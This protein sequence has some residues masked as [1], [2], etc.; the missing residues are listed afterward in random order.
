MLVKDGFKKKK[1]SIVGNK[2]EIDGATIEIKR[3]SEDKDAGTVIGTIL[4]FYCVGVSIVA[5]LLSKSVYSELTS[6]MSLSKKIIICFVL[7]FG[8]FC[9][10][11]VIF[12][13]ARWL[14]YIGYWVVNDDILI[15]V[16]KTDSPLVQQSLK[17][18]AEN[19]KTDTSC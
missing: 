4:A 13:M 1:C 11:S 18:L 3:L 16:E 2:I 10:V 12:L 9:V 14:G 6:Y 8:I 15:Y 17:A 5:F 7:L 19:I